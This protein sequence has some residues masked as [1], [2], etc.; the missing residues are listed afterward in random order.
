MVSFMKL[1]S[2]FMR[3]KATFV[4]PSSLISRIISSRMGS[5]HSGVIAS[6]YKVWVSVFGNT[7]SEHC[8]D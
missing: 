5:M 8:V 6:W 4:N 3:E 1:S 7:E 2:S